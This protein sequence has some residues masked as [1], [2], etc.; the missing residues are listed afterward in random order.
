MISYLQFL[1]KSTNQ[2]GIHSPYVYN[3]LTKGLYHHKK[4]YPTAP[5]KSI[6]LLLS[7]IKYFQF[8]TV[9]C[10]NTEISTVIKN[11]F[12]NI[13]LNTSDNYDLIIIEKL[14]NCESY[15]EQMHNDSLL[16]IL[17]T[18]HQVK[19]NVLYKNHFTLVIDFYHT[20]VFSKRKEQKPQNFFIR[21]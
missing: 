19:K 9:L 12:Q 6:R 21:Y 16:I 14:K 2:H 5:T 18:K 15:L 7:S 10:L 3:Y 4:E 17:N 8:Q 1:I 11:H 13:S 20:L